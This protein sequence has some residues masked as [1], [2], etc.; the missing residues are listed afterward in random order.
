LNTTQRVMRV[1]TH[2]NIGAAPCL[3]AAVLRSS[4][5]VVDG[6]GEV[7]TPLAAQPAQQYRASRQGIEVPYGF[8]QAKQRAGDARE[9]QVKFGAPHSM[10]RAESGVA[11]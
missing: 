9:L 7:A 5:E 1:M 3:A 11:R 2:V 4:L 10:A 8:V 6:E